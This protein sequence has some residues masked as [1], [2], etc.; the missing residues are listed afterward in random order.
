VHPQPAA[1]DGKLKPGLVFGRA[2]AVLRQEGPV[3]LFLYM[4]AAVLHRLGCVGDLQQSAC[5][6]L[7][8][9]ERTITGVF[10]RLGS[11]VMCAS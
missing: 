8:I 3:E 4:D 1:L 11:T 7:G 6:V 9:G 10:H 2:G 5:D